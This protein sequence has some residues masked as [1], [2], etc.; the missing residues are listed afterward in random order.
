MSEVSQDFGMV[1]CTVDPEAVLVTM[2]VVEGKAPIGMPHFSSR[3]WGTDEIDAALCA[4]RGRHARVRSPFAADQ[5]QALIW[6][7]GVIAAACERRLVANAA[8]ALGQ[9][10]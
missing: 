10:R 9:R 6:A 8:A 2:R 7:S 3:L 1:R 5:L 4:A